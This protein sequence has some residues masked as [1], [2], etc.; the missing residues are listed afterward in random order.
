[1]TA[2][3][4]D[5][6]RRDRV[7]IIRLNRPEKR[8][9][10]DPFTIEHLGRAL[11]DAE[12]DAAIDAVVLT[13]TGDRAFCAGMDLAAFAAG[14]TSD[15]GPG[16]QRYND[17]VCT[18]FPKPV[19]A[20]ANGAAVAG[21]FELLLACDLAVAADHA[22]FGIPEVK[23][24]LVAGAGGTLLPYRVPLSVA[25][26]LGLTGETITA[27]R[28]L[29]LGLVNRVVPHEH[30]LDEAVALAARIAAN[31]PFAVALTKSLMYDALEVPASEAWARARAAIPE[32]RAQPDALEGSRAFIEKRTP[33]WA[34][35][36]T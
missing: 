15:D 12:N 17:F 26:E 18:P 20:A 10:L 24:G 19:I 5:V 9:A 32:V 31:S 8:N 30:V 33:R 36:R 2:M 4:V 28:A 22:V 21:G 3:S 34:P 29:E 7:M 16:R 1:M 13:G 25:L 6:E 14:E 35:R 27:Q 23:R 11:I